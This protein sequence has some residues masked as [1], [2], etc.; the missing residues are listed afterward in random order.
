M[1]SIFPIR[2]HGP[3]SARSLELALSEL[4]PD[5]V[6]VEGPSDAGVVLPFL[7]DGALKPPVA[8]L[9]YVNDDPSRAAFWPFAVFSPEFVA[10][11]WAARAGAV[12]RFVD[13]P[14]GVVLAGE[15]DGPEDELRD[16]PLGVLAQAAGFSDF[17]RWWE[18][19]VEARGDDF[20]VFAAVNE[21]M[22]AVRADALAP[23]GRE[24]QRE[25]FMRQGIRAALKA[26][27]EKGLIRREAREVT[28]IGGHMIAPAGVKVANPAFDVTPHR[29]LSGIVTEEGIVRPPFNDGL[30]ERM[31]GFVLN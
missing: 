8:L 13:L 10:L 21:A 4:N 9:G 26:L 14:A 28:H 22:R 5:V 31:L 29:Y 30:R 16:D 15:R 11:R 23:V 12:A 24:A 3:G 20:D 18:S 1:I 7:A 25:A 2:H 19:L 17:E 6:L 27:E